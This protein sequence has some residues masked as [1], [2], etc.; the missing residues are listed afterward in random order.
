ML[1]GLAENSAVILLFGLGA[2]GS[3]L[4]DL[5]SDHSLPVQVSFTLGSILLAFVA[6]FTAASWF[7]T[8]AELA[9][10]WLAVFLLSRHLLFAALSRL[11]THRG[12]FHSIPA[13]LLFGCLTAAFLHWLWQKP[14]PLAWLGGLFVAGGY[15]THLALDEIYKVNLFGLRARRNTSHALKLWYAKSPESSL[16]IYLALVLCYPALPA[17][18]PAL[19]WLRERAPA[20][21]APPL[22]APANGWFRLPAEPAAQPKAEAEAVTP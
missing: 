16:G 7:P 1:A 8:L 22:L 9:V 17:T 14:P 20:A 11:T 19:Q 4:P 10:I 18:E 3:L 12:I 5:D 2:L 13:A 21:D 15:L 6:L